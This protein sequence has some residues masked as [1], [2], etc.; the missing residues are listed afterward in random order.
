MFI[1]P[2]RDSVMVANVLDATLETF[3]K[4]R[5]QFFA[6]HQKTFASTQKKPFTIMQQPRAAACGCRI[7]MMNEE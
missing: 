3:A 4:T 2:I 7:G 5:K 1:H 6:S